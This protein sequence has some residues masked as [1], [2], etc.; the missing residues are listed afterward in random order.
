MIIFHNFKPN[1]KTNKKN[2][3]NS[4]LVVAQNGRRHNFPQSHKEERDN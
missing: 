1:N 2:T 3:N 4:L